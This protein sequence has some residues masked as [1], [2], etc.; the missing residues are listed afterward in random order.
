[1]VCGVGGGGQGWAGPALS[2]VPHPASLPLSPWSTTPLF[3]LSPCARLLPD[4]TPVSYTEAAALRR[5]TTGADAFLSF[6]KFMTVR[7]VDGTV[8]SPCATLQGVVPCWIPCLRL[9]FCVCACLRVCVP[10]H[11]T[12]QPVVAAGDSFLTLQGT[13]QWWS[14][15]PSPAPVLDALF[16]ATLWPTGN[17][18]GDAATLVVRAGTGGA[19]YYVT[20]D[21]G[22]RCELGC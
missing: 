2:C 10:I 16:E 9:C 12:A 5:Y 1:M 18:T 6:S 7:G 14:P 3:N 15:T 19:G 4:G 8:H 22:T 13:G 20:I 21:A 17:A 11:W